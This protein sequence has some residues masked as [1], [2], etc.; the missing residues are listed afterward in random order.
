ML[1]HQSNQRLTISKVE[2]IFQVDIDNFLEN[3]DQILTIEKKTKTLSTMRL[4]F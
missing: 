3:V 4:Q 1:P 2:F